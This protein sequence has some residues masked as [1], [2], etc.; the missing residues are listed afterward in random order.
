MPD[1]EM[2]EPVHAAIEQT[3][4]QELGSF[5]I[6]RV[7]SIET[8]DHDGDPTILVLVHY[9]DANAEPDPQVAA[10]TITKVN[11][12]LFQLDEPRFAHILHKVPDPAPCGR[13]R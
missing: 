7:E 4:R 2:T 11:D 3:I 9:R 10:A 1:I 8:E 13:R 12:R 5:G 6:E